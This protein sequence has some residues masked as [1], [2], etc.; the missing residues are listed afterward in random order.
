M[1]LRDYLAEKYSPGGADLG[2][3]AIERALGQKGY[4]LVE[5]RYIESETNAPFAIT[6][7]AKEGLVKNPLIHWTH[8]V[9]ADPERGVYEHCDTAHELWRFVRE[10]PDAVPAPEALAHMANAGDAVDID[11][12]AEEPEWEA[13]RALSDITAICHA[14]LQLLGA[15]AS[16]ANFEGLAD[17]LYARMATLDAALDDLVADRG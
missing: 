16:P 11:T 15:E 2:M 9:S 5:A 4:D 10:L 12:A 8:R 17:D 13:Q 14:M 3:Q 1:K 7:R 6:L